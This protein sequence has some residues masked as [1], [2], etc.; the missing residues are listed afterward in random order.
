MIRFVLSSKKNFHLIW[1]LWKKA[2]ERTDT[3]QQE[4]KDTITLCHYYFYIII[5]I[6]Y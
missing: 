5:I 2:V 4:H 3:A 6:Y 1:E